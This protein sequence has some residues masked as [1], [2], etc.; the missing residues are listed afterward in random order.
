MNGQEAKWLQSFDSLV[1]L[2]RSFARQRRS[3]RL[4][5]VTMAVG[6]SIHASGL[7][8]ASAFYESLLAVMDVLGAPEDREYLP[9]PNPERVYLGDGTFLGPVLAEEYGRRILGVVGFVIFTLG[10]TILLCPLVGRMIGLTGRDNHR[11]NQE[12][13]DWTD[14]LGTAD[15]A[16]LS[17]RFRTEPT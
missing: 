10:A 12:Q 17:S 13:F 2:R 15:R 8:L 9:L 11:R 4:G 1:R 3:T 14:R 6:Y 7:F 16:G 5:L